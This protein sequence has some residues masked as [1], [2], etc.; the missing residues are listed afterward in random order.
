MQQAQRQQL[1][2]QQEECINF[3]GPHLLI[4]GP[5]GSGKTFVLLARAKH[6]AE[7]MTSPSGTVLLLTFNK[8]LA[9]Y[10]QEQLRLNGVAARIGVHTYHGW[11]HRVLTENNHRPQVISGADRRRLLGEALAVCR[12]T[13][14]A[15]AKSS[16]AVPLL[17]SMDWW[18]DEI[19]WIKGRAIGEWEVYRT[20][21]RTGRG[22]GLREQGRYVVWEVLTAYQQ[23]LQA[24]RLCDFRDYS[25]QLLALGTPLPDRWRVEHILID[26]AQDLHYADL[27]VLTHIARASTTVVADRTQKIYQTGFTWR[28][29][30]FDITGGSRSRVLSKSYRTTRQIALLAASLQRQETLVRPGDPDYTID[31]LPTREGPVP[32]IY[33]IR[34]RAH[35][36]ATV[37]RLLTE[38]TTATFGNTIGLLA[39]SRGVLTFMENMLQ[40]HQIRYERIL[41][42]DGSTLT[43][44]IKLTTFHSAKG[45][46]FSDV[47]LV[48]LTE[49]IFPRLLASERSSNGDDSSD[50]MEALA[51]ARRLLYVAM[52]RAKRRLYLLHGRVPSC[53]IGEFDS[54]LYRHT[55]PELEATAPATAFTS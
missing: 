49:G 42:G 7:Q 50:H 12:T 23:R 18:E 19:D 45:L 25:L 10:V 43:P 47:V 28:D 20:I 53:F 11:A 9:H 8:S 24:R 29:L 37:V 40:Q 52:T 33:Q 3:A 22:Q 1:G 35:E 14:Q 31:S 2:Q 34:N 30:G 17:R 6:L 5:P 13:L 55:A 27:Q 41:D 51:T 48:G 38:L 32:V 54:T 21:E 44:G 4:S 26:E 36:A 46:E 16:R 39:P 15:P